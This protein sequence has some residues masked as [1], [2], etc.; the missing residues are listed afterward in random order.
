MQIFI[1]ARAAR[2]LDN[3]ADWTLEN[4]GVAQM[5]RYLRR[6]YLRMD[7]L[8]HNPKLGRDRSDI[9]A[10]LRSV[11]EQSHLIFYLVDHA[12]VSIVAVLH[13]SMD[14]DGQLG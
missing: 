2:D 13:Q 9:A 4:W 5:E 3:I 10:G 11:H 8:K 14:V 1:T 12:G 7:A 6:L